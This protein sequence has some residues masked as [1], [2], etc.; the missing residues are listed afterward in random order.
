MKNI[1]KITIVLAMLVSMSGCATYTVYKH[2]EQKVA[3][4]KAVASG[5]QAAIKAVDLGNG[6]VGVGIDV[7]NWE[8][9]SEQPLM[10]LGAA[11]LDAGTIW[12]AKRGI[13]SMNGDGSSDK[14]TTINVTGNENNLTIINGHNN[15]TTSQPNIDSEN[16]AP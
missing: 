4:K 3:M 9:L 15:T 13:D 8:A 14:A 6:A 12:A 7:S 16:T 5:N 10:Q 11:L 2:S 1:L